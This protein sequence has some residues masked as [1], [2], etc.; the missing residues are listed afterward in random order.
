MHTVVNLSETILVDHFDDKFLVKDIATKESRVLNDSEFHG[1]SY[2]YTCD[3]SRKFLKCFEGK[4]SVIYT[5][6]AE[7]AYMRLMAANRDG[8]FDED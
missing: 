8:I 2:K 1:N 6:I 3:F 7:A 4:T 5:H